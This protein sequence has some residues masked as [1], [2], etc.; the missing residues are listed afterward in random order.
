MNFDL[1]LIDDKPIEQ[2]PRAALAMS[3]IYDKPV[4]IVFK[5]DLGVKLPS[6]SLRVEY[7]DTVSDANSD[8][9]MGVERKLI[10]FGI[11]GHATLPDSDIAQ[12]YRFAYQKH[13]YTIMSVITTIGEIQA[14]AEVV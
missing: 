14:S 13:E 10:L 11:R 7:D 2:S 5:T 1:W 8:A 12:G 3:A 6:Q 9:G 4:P